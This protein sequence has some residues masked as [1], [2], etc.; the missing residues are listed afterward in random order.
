[1]VTN[2]MS[3]Y[4]TILAFITHA[5]STAM[6]KSEAQAVARGGG[7]W[8]GGAKKMSAGADGLQAG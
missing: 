4:N 2:M 8:C 7:R 6:A 3:T 5:Q 1:M